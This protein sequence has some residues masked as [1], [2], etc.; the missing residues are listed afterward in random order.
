[1]RKGMDKG[2]GS[3]YRNIVGKDPY[4]HK[5]SA[6]GI[7]QPQMV[8][9]YMAWEQMPKSK[10][11]KLKIGDKV[12]SKFTGAKGTVMGTQPFFV[13]KYDYKGKTYTYVTN[14]SFWQKGGKLDTKYK[15]FAVY[16]VGTLPK[17]AKVRLQDIGRKGHSL[18]MVYYKNGKWHTYQY[19]IKK[20]DMGSQKTKQLL[21]QIKAKHQ[22]VRGGKDMP[23]KEIGDI[24]GDLPS[25]TTVE[26]G[27]PILEGIGRAVGTGIDAVV[28]G[29]K[30]IARKSAEAFEDY[31]ER[32]AEQQAE[33]LA[34]VRSEIRPQIKKIKN[35]KE[36]VDTL[37]EHIKDQEDKGLE[38]YSERQELETEQK[39][40]REMQ[41]KA[42][43]IHIEDLSNRELQILAIKTQDSGFFDFG[44]NKYERELLRR[45]KTEREL[46]VKIKK[47]KTE[48]LNKPFWG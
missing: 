41:E 36:R 22:N 28:E 29:T 17:N 33:E 47:A 37:N 5:M 18:R 3:G 8:Q 20:E 32:K 9:N 19:L 40:L 44:T 6:Q 26:K 30:T 38:T 35:Q 42:T 27:H 12:T 25:G 4:V 14:P 39:Q 10:N 46:G 31:K 24:I 34:Q 16:R 23:V 43:N 15:N 21:T 1:M 13:V 7:K 45:I 48:P 11:L 2:H